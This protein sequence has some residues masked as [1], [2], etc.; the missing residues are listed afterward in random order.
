MDDLCKEAERLVLQ[1]PDTK[2]H[3]EVRKLQMQEQLK[4][5]VLSAR[6]HLERLQQMQ[7]LQ[8]YFQEYRDLIAWISRLKN[9]IER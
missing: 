8:S 1:Y 7:N 3:V 4:D 2:E 9:T 6:K 5:V